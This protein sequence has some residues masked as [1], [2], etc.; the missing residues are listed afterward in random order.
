[1]HLAGFNHLKYKD[2]LIYVSLVTGILAGL[3]GGVS[4]MWDDAYKCHQIHHMKKDIL[5]NFM[6]I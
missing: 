6:Q 3:L 4:A 2:L 1:M 5:A